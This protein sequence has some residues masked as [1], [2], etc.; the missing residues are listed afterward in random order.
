MPQI[1]LATGALLTLTGLTGFLLTGSTHYTALIPAAFGVLFILGGWLAFNPMCLKHAMHA[2][3]VIALLGVLGSVR[4]LAQLPNLLS[5]QAVA[6]PPAVIAQSFMAL[7]CLVF[8]GFAVSS[9]IQARR[10]R[11]AS[12]NP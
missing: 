9:F 8:I 6:R 11:A 1:S 5:G 12:I 3:A 10:H 4:G 7:I 2:T